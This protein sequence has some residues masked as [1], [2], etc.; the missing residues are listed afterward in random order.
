MKTIKGPAIFLAQ[1]MGDS[2]PFDTLQNLASWAA[3]LGYKGIQVPA[4]ARLIDLEKPHRATPTVTTFAVPWKTRACR[5]PNCR[6]ICK[7]N[8]LRCIPPTTHCSMAS[9]RRM[10]AA[11]R[12]RALNGRSRN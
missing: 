3:S 12:R 1:F 5:S 10:C 11:I 7:G 6:R 8:S 9:P 2:A 4:D